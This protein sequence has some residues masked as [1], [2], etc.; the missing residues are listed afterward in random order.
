MMKNSV[1]YRGILS[2]VLDIFNFFSKIYDVANC[3][4]TVINHKIENI[5]ENVG[6]VLFKV[7]KGN[8]SQGRHKNNS[9]YAVA[10]ATILLPGLFKA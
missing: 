6:W 7:V 1:F 2:L 5:T 3:T 10:M 9:I 4:M 8:L